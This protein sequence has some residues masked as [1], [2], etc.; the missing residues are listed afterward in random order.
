MAKLKIKSN[1]WITPNHILNNKNLSFR[2][3]GL[4]WYLQSK[5]ENRDFSIHRIK[6]DTKE[7]RDAVNV[8]LQ[9]LEKNGFLVRRKYQDSKWLRNIEYILSENPYTENPYTEKPYTENTETNKKRISKKELVKKNIYNHFKKTF[10]NWIKLIKKNYNS[11][12]SLKTSIQKEKKVPA[13]KEKVNIIE[14]Q[15]KQFQQF[16]E[17]YPRK[18]N[19]QKAKLKFFELNEKTKQKAIE[20]AKKYSLQEKQKWTEIN[21][22][23]HPTTRLNSGCRDD[24]YKY[25]NE[26]KAKIQEL[27]SII[28]E[29]WWSSKFKQKYWEEEYKRIYSLKIKWKCRT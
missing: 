23:K 15:E 19:K 4:F 1:Y 25:I 2:A 16:W 14:K 18:V 22:I 13:K 29:Y 6:H 21:Y 8:W 3:K 26:D 20:S 10:K 5:P 9:E 27:N 11:Y 17:H 12:K 24:E 28:K 7:W